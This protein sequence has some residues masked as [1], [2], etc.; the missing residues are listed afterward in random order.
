MPA[1]APKFGTMRWVRRIGLGP[2]VLAGVVINFT[3]MRL[4][5]SRYGLSALT[6]ARPPGT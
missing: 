5:A 4:W 1:K 6:A 2:A 3:F